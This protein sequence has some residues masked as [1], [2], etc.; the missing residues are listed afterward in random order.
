MPLILITLS[1]ITGL[2]TGHAFLYFPVTV[3]VLS[4]LSL[5]AVFLLRRFAGPAP[6]R[7]ALTVL[8]AI[9]GLLAYLYSAAWFPGDHV[10][11]TF[12]P[13]GKRHEAA[14][15]IVSPL[16]RGPG[17]T[18]FVLRLSSI[19]DVAMTGAV[20]VSVRDEL[21]SV[22]YG[23]FVRLSGRLYE[24]RGFGNPGG[25][26]YAAFL[27]R[28]GISHSLG[29][30][31]DGAITVISAGSGPFRK[32][33]D[34]RER[35]RQ[36]F[37]SST[38]GPGSAVL[39]AMVLGEEGGLTDDVRDRFMAAGVTH[40]LSISGSHLGLIAVICFGLI[41]AALFI[42]PER[43]YHQLTLRVD[44]RK[45]A[46]WLTVLPVTFYAL[47]A[48]GQTATL[49]SLVM[50]LAALAALVLDR[51]NSL[52]HSLAAAALVILVANP[53]AVFDISFQLSYLS[54][55]AI[56][57]VV[58]LWK[59]LRIQAT[60][61]IGRV[62]NGIL[63]LV[64]VSLTASLATGPL[65]A[66]YFNQF[67]MAGLVSNMV[68]V[69]FAGFVVVPLGLFSGI[70]SL[71]TGDLPL[72]LLNQLASDVFYGAVS[73]FARL[74]FAEFHPPA[75]GPLFLVAYYALLF[76]CA[77]YLRARV[78]Y[79][80]RPLEFSARPPALL[81][82]VM[83]A[84][85]SVLLV[86]VVVPLL[87]GRP[88][89]VT[90]IDV[91]QGDATIVKLASGRN[92]LIDGGGTYDNR[93]D[94]GRRVVAP[95]LWN[96]GVRTVDLAVLSHP[97]PDHMNGMASILRAFR[98]KRL[99]ADPGGREVKG[100]DEFI[101]AARERQVPVTAVTADGTDHRVGEAVLRVLHPPPSF[102]SRSKQAYSRENDRSLV[103]RIETDGFSLLF[104]GDVG[105]EAEAALVSSGERLRVDV[106]KVPHHGSRHSSTPAFVQAAR[107][108][109][110]V[111]SVGKGNP[112]RQ[113]AEDVVARYRDAG[114]DVYRTDRHG[115]VTLTVRDGALSVTAWS[116][117]I[118]RRISLGHM[119]EWGAK[120]R[121]NWRR[122]G[123]RV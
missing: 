28:Q 100:Y 22:G 105:N 98:V 90:F 52:L 111:V 27:A 42:L 119:R 54:V 91:G 110:A 12:S 104:S 46:A 81:R 109:L 41:R 48:G 99:W 14:G 58:L 94:V 66:L 63:V 84:S 9:A 3:S 117:L 17:R 31:D 18:A 101:G 62:R 107:P 83:I 26:D 23:D 5:S 71:F 60:G 34:W 97:H 40:I 79:N 106:L 1:S 8:P 121:E 76:A 123:R 61:R 53:Q 73:F 118:L 120:E 7:I 89:T 68:V 67:S 32:I 45:L 24:P 88:T 75:P 86:L 64:A 21:D 87:A 51:E 4:M 20:R 56:G 74:P 50:I 103:V 29:V 16:D 69:P 59:D 113:P 43:R 2:L 38:S 10:T 35:I 25:F 93:F 39:Q 65:V 102:T 13:D 122:V 55:V 6:R 44:P 49:R 114:A 82:P 96:H 72:S 36:A 85:F 78:L 95:Y 33:Q 108:R 115:A 19:D 80:L 37:R 77:A 92:I 30:K 47:L 57:C 11:R 70:L 112:Y 116:D 15:T